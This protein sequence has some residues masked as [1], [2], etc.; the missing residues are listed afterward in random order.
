MRPPVAS[1]GQHRSISLACWW[2][3]AGGDTCSGNFNSWRELYHDDATSLGLKYDV[4]NANDLAGT[5]M[6]ALGYDGSSRDLWQ[7][8]AAKFTP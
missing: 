5:G 7:V 6:W 3:P 8:L 2:S 1:L 4:V